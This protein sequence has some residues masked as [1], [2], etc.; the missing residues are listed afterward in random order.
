MNEKTLEF[1]P[2]PYFEI[3]VT[4][5]ILNRS[6]QAND[7]FNKELDIWRLFHINDRQKAIELISRTTRTEPLTKEL[8]LKTLNGSFLSFTCT[9]NWEND[10][11]Y[12]ICVEKASL[13]EC[14]LES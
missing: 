9:I 7:L 3:N 13:S 1:F 2:L 10:I 12:L 5:E 8:R 6:K 14:K 4:G 11:A